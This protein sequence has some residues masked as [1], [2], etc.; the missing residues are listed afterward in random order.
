MPPA[1][2]LG[3]KA[4]VPADAHGCPLCPHPCTGPAITGSTD[5]LTNSLPAF[6]KDDTGLHAACCNTNMF[7]ATKGSGT[8]FINNKEAMRQGDKTKHCGGNGNMIEGS[9]NVLIGG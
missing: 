1:A 3:D 5:V 6:R 9:G 4:N 8:V 7:Q 2:R